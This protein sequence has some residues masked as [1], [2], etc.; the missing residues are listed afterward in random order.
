MGHMPK[1][2]MYPEKLPSSHAVADSAVERSFSPCTRAHAILQHFI[3]QP[4]MYSGECGN[5]IFFWHV[6]FRRLHVLQRRRL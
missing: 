5:G 4:L 6:S 3:L 1:G 2:N